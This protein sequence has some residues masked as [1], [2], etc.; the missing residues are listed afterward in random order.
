MNFFK[1]I[2]GDQPDSLPQPDLQFGR[3]TDSYKSTEQYDAW[4]VSLEKFEEKEYLESYRQFLTYLTDPKEENV[5]WEEKEGTITFEIFQGS[6][7]IYGSA[8]NKQFQAIAKIA[9]TKSLHI[10]FMRRLVEQNFDLK[11]ARFALTPDDEIVI[12]FN[13]PT[14][15]NSP[16]KVYYAL[17]ELATQ[18]DKQDDLLLDEFENLIPL[19]NQHIIELPLEEKNI[20]LEFI[21]QKIEKTLDLVDNGALSPDRYPGAVAY[22]MLDLCYR[23]DFLISPEGY[24]TDLLERIQRKY[25]EN[26]G[27]PTA[28]K[29]QYMYKELKKL[30]K[31]T[32]EDYFKEMYRVKSTFGI[33]APV[34][35]DKIISFIDGEIQNMDWYIDNKHD[36]VALAIPGY[37]IGYCLFNYAIPKPILDLFKLYYQIFE[38]ELFEKLGFKERYSNDGMIDKKKVNQAFDRIEKGNKQLYPKLEINSRKLNFSSSPR[39]AKSY[40]E[41]IKNLDLIRS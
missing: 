38:P 3:Y 36:Q 35:L 13:T 22:L 33:T 7:K 23:M 28:H 14:V 21:R 32:K 27:Q 2:F 40:L 1:K 12:M 37:I 26:N 16:Y 15:D 8:D 9:K 17:K 31:R 29:N 5:I 10:G 41:M 24:M 30:Q 34:N 19:S 4:D 20:K 18:A 11:Y 39:F 6:K 25:F